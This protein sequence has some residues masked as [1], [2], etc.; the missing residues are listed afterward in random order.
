MPMRDGLYKVHFQTPRGA[1]DGVIVL[2]DGQL[3]GG[4]SLIYYV[5]TYTQNGDRFSADVKTDAHSNNPNMQSVFGM[6]RVRIN[7]TGT[8]KGDSAQMTG[9]SPDA[10]GVNFQASLTRLAD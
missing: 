1:G 4:D 3:R 10:P 9:T 2:K 6:N 8:T 5:G 7:I